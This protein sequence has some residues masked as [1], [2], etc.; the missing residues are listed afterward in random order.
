MRLFLGFAISF[1]LS[2]PLWAQ[3]VDPDFR[4]YII[5]HQDLPDD[6]L[7]QKVTER[8]ETVRE[9]DVGMR[10]VG[11]T[12][13]RSPDNRFA[14]FNFLWESCGAYCNPYN[15]VL[16][17][18]SNEDTTVFSD[19]L[20]SEDWQVL[21]VD[22]IIIMDPE[23]AL[24]L[25][26]GSAWGRPRGV[27]GISSIAFHL[28][29]LQGYSLSQIWSH[30]SFDSN[31]AYEDEEDSVD[32]LEFIFHASDSTISY[33]E[34]GYEEAD[35]W[36]FTRQHGRYKYDPNEGTFFEIEHLGHWW[37]EGNEE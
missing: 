7:A 27:E 37:L 23:R 33:R 8:M 12:I 10:P 31:L 35:P 28:L 30:T 1:L 34:R 5:D 14:I 17:R 22:S 16:V 20:E 18:Y 26:A 36:I 19:W 13:N 32:G 25:L 6:Q 11:M 21:S 9:E 3:E 24:Y 2:L 29:Q 15:E 4:Q